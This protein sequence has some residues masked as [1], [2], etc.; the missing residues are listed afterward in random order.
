[1][2]SL[3]FSFGYM[4][5]N[6]GI[7]VSRMRVG[8]G[9]NKFSSLRICIM[10]RIEIYRLWGLD[11]DGRTE[12]CQLQT[13]YGNKKMT[14]LYFIWGIPRMMFIDLG[15]LKWEGI[16]IRLTMTNKMRRKMKKMNKKLP[17][18]EIKISDFSFILMKYAFF[19]P[20]VHL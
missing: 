19:W 5:M 15:E 9:G 16:Q 4:I 10:L 11:G 6:F 7:A 14:I 20:L 12:N 2:F 1:M 18:F 17:W 3:D 8:V 13:A